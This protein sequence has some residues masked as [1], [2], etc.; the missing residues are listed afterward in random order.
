MLVIIGSIG[1]KITDLQCIINA[2]AKAELSIETNSIRDCFRLGK[3]KHDAQRPRPI[4][5]KFLRS[6]EA[7]MVLSK[8]A[9][10]QA[11]VV[12]KPDLTPEERKIESFLLGFEKARI[13]IRNRSILVDVKLYQWS[14]QK[15]SILQ[16]TV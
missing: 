2:F 10:F 13:K 4:L 6:N 16:I 5:I 14:I 3:F 15:F 9:A 7:T 11:L 1:D 12:I 8:I